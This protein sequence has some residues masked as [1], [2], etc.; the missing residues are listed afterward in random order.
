MYGASC[1]LLFFLT[2]IIPPFLCFGQAFQLTIA[3]NKKAAHIPE[4]EEPVDHPAEDAKRRLKL[5]AVEHLSA[6]A[7]LYKSV[8]VSHSFKSTAHHDVL[9]MAGTVK[10][11]NPNGETLPDAQMP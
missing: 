9:E 3:P 11:G 10:S 4:Q 6:P 8:V 7:G 1:C 2:K 5:E